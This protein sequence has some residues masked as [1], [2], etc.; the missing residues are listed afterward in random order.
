MRQQLAEI[1][2]NFVE[3]DFFLTSQ[4]LFAIWAE[5]QKTFTME[6]FYRAQR[7]RLDILMSG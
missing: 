3:N 5:T 7:K 2:V 1:G 6:N 4:E